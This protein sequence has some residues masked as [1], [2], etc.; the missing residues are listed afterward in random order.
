MI[1]GEDIFQIQCINFT[2]PA[3]IIGIHC[4]LLFIFHLKDFA[5]EKE[6]LIYLNATAKDQANLLLDAAS[7][8]MAMSR[9]L[10]FVLT[11]YQVMSAL[12]N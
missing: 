10:I 4:I 6:N 7:V 12:Q 8:S 3:R 1:S 5:E 9:P 2:I 11:P